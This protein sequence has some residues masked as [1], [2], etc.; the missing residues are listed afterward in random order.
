[1]VS[2]LDGVIAKSSDEFIDWS[3]KEDK[4]HFFNITKEK[5]ALIMG[6][7][8]FDTMPKPL[9][10]RQNIVLTSDPERYKELKEKYEN[11]HFINA[12]S[13]KKVLEFV[14]GL[15]FEE[16]VIGGGA[17]INSF[18]AK[19]NLIDFVYLTLEPVFVG[20][21]IKLFDGNLRMNL[22]LIETE[23]LNENTLLLKYKVKK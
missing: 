11:L 22:E 13:A 6:S 3:S 7:S 9:P 12:E 14:A 15:G 4:K 18:F 16:V 5:G 23:N 10:D 20:E 17:K 2:S 1:M 21:G 8:T 19:E